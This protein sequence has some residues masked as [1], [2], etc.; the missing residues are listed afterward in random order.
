[1][2][3]VG[4]LARGSRR[5]PTTDH[6]LDRPAWNTLQ[7]AWRP[8]AQEAG[9]ALRLEPD[10]G[11]FA[12]TP[13]LTA[14]SLRD[15][16]GFD[17]GDHG[18]DLIEPVAVEAPLGLAVTQQAN[19]VQMTAEA[20]AS[21]GRE[22][23]AA[24]LDEADGAQMLAL[25]QLTRPGPFAAR[26]HRL[27]GF[28][29]VRSEG[30]LVAMAGERMRPEGFCEVSGVCT[31]PDHRGCGYAGALMRLVARRIL[32][33]GETPFLHCFQTNTG[34]I[35]LYEMLGFRL[36]RTVVLTVLKQA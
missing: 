17:I 10:Y 24:R 22:F 31:H 30:R 15:L 35:A 33:R 7:G 19:L 6:P 12:G 32:D 9:E 27:G 21:G 11:P 28:I 34:A 8:L 4:L 20:I 29:G 36:R 2:V 25:A 18:L 5:L 23:E 1:M 14:A 26:T 16:A 3:T 13:G